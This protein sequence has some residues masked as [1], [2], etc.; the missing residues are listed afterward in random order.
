MSHVF[1]EKQ[2][3]GST[4]NQTETIVRHID[5]YNFGLDKDRANYV[6]LS[7]LRFI[8]RAAPVCPDHIAV[9]HGE[10]QQLDSRII[11]TVE[12]PAIGDIADPSRLADARTALRIIIHPLT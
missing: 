11:G 5:P 3:R 10:R 12:G 7:P 9:I 4:A 6:P 2:P 1:T 8:E